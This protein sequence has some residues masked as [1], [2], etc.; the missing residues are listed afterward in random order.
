GWLDVSASKPAGAH[1]GKVAGLEV[2]VEVEPQTPPAPLAR[3]AG[4]GVS[5]KNS[6][7]L[8]K[9]LELAE[10][11]DVETAVDWIYGLRLSTAARDQREQQP[12]NG[13]HGKRELGHIRRRGA[14]LLRHLPTPIRQ[15]PPLRLVPLVAHH[16]NRAH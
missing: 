4:V 10:R 5:D 11:R 6:E 7:W 8:Q 1:A 16:E 12:R 15:S 13:S 9:A 3:A 14:P 2:E